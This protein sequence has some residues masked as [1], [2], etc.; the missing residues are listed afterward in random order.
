MSAEEIFMEGYTKGERF[1]RMADEWIAANGPTWEWMK[2]KARENALEKRGFSVASLVEEAR[3]TKPVQGVDAYKINHDIRPVLG[4]KLKKEVPE[5]ASVIR[6]RDS[7][8][9]LLEG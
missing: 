8:V 4:R 3:Y 6:T 9:D 7:V 5:C 2:R 1:V